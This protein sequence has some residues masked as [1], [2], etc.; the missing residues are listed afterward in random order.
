MKLFSSLTL[1]V[2]LGAAVAAAPLPKEFRALLQEV[3]QEAISLHQ[4]SQVSTSLL[5]QPSTSW[6][7]QARHLSATREALNRMSVNFRELWDR[8]AEVTPAEREAIRKTRIHLFEAI[9]FQRAAL[10]ALQ[11]QNNLTSA[12]PFGVAVRGLEE[13][14]AA[15]RKSL[16]SARELA[17]LQRKQREI[18]ATLVAGNAN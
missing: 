13:N 16:A 14:A 11:A 5:W 9:H 8:Q 7:T 3:E 18:Q 10:Q 2:S 12:A 17:R 6:Q 1:F 4:H 15:M